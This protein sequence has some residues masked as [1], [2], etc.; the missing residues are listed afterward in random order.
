MRMVSVLYISENN[1]LTFFFIIEKFSKPVYASV[2]V[3]TNFYIYVLY[4][5]YIQC[6]CRFPS[7]CKLKLVNVA[8]LTLLGFYFDK[9]IF[10]L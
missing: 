10:F 9:C 3:M 6:K 1:A 7:T 8:Y 2:L 5:L 4:T